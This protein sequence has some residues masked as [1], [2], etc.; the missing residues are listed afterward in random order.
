M[1][2]DRVESLFPLLNSKV[3]S[4]RP[5]WL[6]GSCVFGPWLHK[7]GVDAHPSF[8]IQY[9]DTKKSIFKCFSCGRG[10]DLVD[11]VM[12]LRQFLAKEQDSRYDLP[13]AMQLIA[14]EFEEQELD[15]DVPWYEDAAQKVTKDI[16]FPEEWLA[17]FQP[18][19]RFREA[20]DY[21]HHRHLPLRLVGHLDVRFDAVSRRV[22]FPYRNGQGKLVGLQGR[23]IDPSNS[24]RYLQ[25]RYQAKTNPWAWLGEEGVDFD[26]PVVLCE[27]PFDLARIVQHYPNVMAS[28]TSGLSYDKLRRLSSA[29]ELVTFYDYGKGGDEARKKVNKAYPNLPRTHLV[30]PADSGD[31]GEMDDA[32]IRRS[33][34]P[35]V[36]LLPEDYWEDAHP[37]D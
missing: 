2:R 33:L 27:G 30:P 11:L 31:P 7:N 3:V 9:S 18:V 26:Q 20:M 8:G 13:G 14:L 6:I 35:Y 25:Y 22:C 32:A 36:K 29:S 21:L 16:L 1:K 4:K 23:A 17:T 5:G 10:G 15:L 28:F 19:W 24:L 37:H 34:A 12:D